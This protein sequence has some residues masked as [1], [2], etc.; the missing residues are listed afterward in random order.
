[1]RRED[2]REWEKKNDRPYLFAGEGR[3]ANNAAWL[4]AARAELTV[5][6]KDTYA[7]VQ[8]DLVKAF[9]Y[10]PYVKLAEGATILGYPR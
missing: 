4:M 9:E 10:V 7:Q 6:E 8:L 1:M 3:S 5:A 2:A